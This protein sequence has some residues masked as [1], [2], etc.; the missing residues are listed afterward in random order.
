MFSASTKT[1]TPS[2]SGPDPQFNYVTMLLHGDGTNGAQNNTFVDGSTNNFSITR[3]GNTTQGSFSPYGSN[4][5]NYFNGGSG[6]TLVG[7][8]N[9]SMTAIGTG[10][11]T[12]EFWV[13]LADTGIDQHLYDLGSTGF[14]IF[15]SSSL[16]KF[17]VFNRITG[18]DIFSPS[19]SYTFN[20]WVH[21]AVVKSGTGTNQTNLYINGV[22]S[23]TATNSSTFTSTSVTIGSR[24]ALFS[25][26]AYGALGYMSNVR[27][28]NTV[29]YSAAFTPSTTPLT[30]ISGTQLLTCQSNR[31]IDNSTNAL[32]LTVNG[33][34]SVQRFNPFGTATAY[35][36][37]V[38]GGSGYFDGSGDYLACGSQS[39]YAFG[40]GDFTLNVWV[41]LTSAPT[42]M[43]IADTRNS[44][45][46]L[47]IDS[48]RSVYL[49]SDIGFFFIVQSSAG[50]VPLNAWTYITVKRTSGTMTLYVNAVSVA[51][52]SNSTNFTNTVL[53]VGA[54][55][56]GGE[57]F[58]GYISDFQAIK[59]TGVTPTLPTAPLTNVTNTSLLLNY[60][61][62]AIFDNAM[63]NDLETAGTAQIST[64]VKKYGTGSMYFSGSSDWLSLLN[65][66]TST[67]SGV[68][69]WTIE[70]WIY[71]TT[72]DGV[73]RTIYTSGYPIQIFL[74]SGSV[75]IYL[76]TNASGGPYF[77]N[78]LGGPASSVSA[79]VWTHFAV[80]NN[81]NTYTVY[82]NGVGGTSSTS[83]TSI[84][85][86]SN[87][88]ATIGD[89]PVFGSYPYIGYI[90][91][92]RITKG[93]ARYTA[94]F[95]PPTAAFS[96]TGP[97]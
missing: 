56:S 33:S 16:N 61:N 27:Y 52:A 37:A 5:S 72:V 24:F 20:T 28:N 49:Y 35:S 69:S 95:T 83:S 21:I 71:P 79:N 7:L 92:F 32:T 66:P 48:G 34:P 19:I 77:I 94:N 50:A 81:A 13:N 58:Y 88:N 76:S 12:I 8:T 3:N 42:Y 39:A 64:S 54:N 55:T 85:F 40:T 53:T 11:F 97:Y 30:A 46:A 25:G 44:G 4:W 80:V 36:T 23:A 91:D 38:I 96:N 65:T 14:S 6:A 93:Y 89:A 10:N 29:V 9:S 74:K 60:T 75:E 18:T 63:I 84:A 59:G 87:P 57:P 15:Y 43:S 82:V 26:A 47:A 90:D 45:W 1:S 2:G 67:I 31:F 73:F 41:Y 62:G 86:P 22:L 68:G 17:N 70:G 51:T 78:G